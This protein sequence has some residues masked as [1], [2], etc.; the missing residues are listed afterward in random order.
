MNLKN[1]TKSLIAMLCASSAL[2]GAEDAMVMR[3]NGCKGPVLCPSFPIAA[4]DEGCCQTWH[5]DAGLLWQ[6]PGF[7]GMNAGTA[8]ITQF[9][10]TDTGGN[11][12][13]RNVE[14]LSKC[15]K[16]DLGLT[17]S[18]GHLSKHDYW[19]VGARF[20]WI[21]S[22]VNTTDD[23]VNMQYEANANFNTGVLPSS[24]FSTSTDYWTKISYKGKVDYYQLDVLLSRGAFYGRCYSLEPFAGVKVLWY[25]TNQTA[26]Y[27]NTSIFAAGN[28]GIYNETMSNWGA[29]LMF[30]MNGVYNIT[31]NIAIFS[32]SDVAVLYGE[33]KNTRISTLTKGTGSGDG[34]DITTDRTVTRKNPSNCQYYLPVRSIVGVQ[35]AS[36]CLDDM[37]YVAVK[38]GYDARMVVTAT[39]SG[40]DF[41]MNG[42]YC[43]FIW[44][45]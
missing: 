13:N 20:D 4:P 25:D 31:E 35:L 22:T 37:H 32:D 8:W 26:N 18:L 15:F 6:Q 9:M 1:M 30:G 2:F 5:L 34:S 38:I 10:S 29:G 40:R 39:S 36:Y 17:V 16:Y 7:S 3:I 28:Y 44:D 27:F 41:V 33:S 23:N 14:D 12:V 19:F 21:S 43:N 45:F 24:L 42:L 11:Y